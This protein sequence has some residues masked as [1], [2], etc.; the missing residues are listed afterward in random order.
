MIHGGQD[1]QTTLAISQEPGKLKDHAIELAGQPL[2]F[3]VQPG[4][5]SY[6]KNPSDRWGYYIIAPLDPDF[7]K[8]L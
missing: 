8:I 1:Y 5:K 7:P 2:E 6:A 3:E 4:H